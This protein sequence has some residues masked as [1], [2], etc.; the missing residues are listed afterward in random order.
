[1]V[2][3]RFFILRLPSMAPGQ[4]TLPP[5]LQISVFLAYMGVIWRDNETRGTNKPCYEEDQNENG[6]DTCAEY[7]EILRRERN[8]RI[9]G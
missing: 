7:V 5:N 9:A 6:Q 2:N 8:N 4:E 1:M 3:F